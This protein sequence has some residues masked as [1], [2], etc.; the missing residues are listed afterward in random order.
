MTDSEKNLHF[1]CLLLFVFVLLLGIRAVDGNLGRML[2]PEPEFRTAAVGYEHGWAF[3]SQGA[4]FIFPTANLARLEVDGEELTVG[5]AASR[6]R[7]P[8]AVKL[9]HIDQLRSMVDMLTN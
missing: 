7:L 4:S 2:L 1:I 3:H 5:F 9:F 8:L 6:L